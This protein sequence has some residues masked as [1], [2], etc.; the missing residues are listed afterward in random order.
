MAL[1]GAT[2]H[3]KWFFWMFII[4][5][6][7]WLIIGSFKK[8]TSSGRQANIPVMEPQSSGFVQPTPSTV[9]P[10][11]PF[12]NLFNFTFPTS[13]AGPTFNAPVQPAKISEPKEEPDPF[14]GQLSEDEI[15][16]ELA[17]VEKQIE[18]LLKQ[19]EKLEEEEK[20]S[21][22]YGLVFL[23]KGR[24]ELTNPNSEYVLITSSSKLKEPV[25]LID[26]TITSEVTGKTM[27]I[28][29]AS[30]FPRIGGRNSETWITLGPSEKVYVTTGDS[31]LGVSF[32]VNMCSGFLDQ[33]VGYNPALP[34]RC[35]DP[36]NDIERRTIVNPQGYSDEC[37]DYVNKIGRCRAIT[38][39]LPKT[40][41]SSC[42]EFIKDINYNNCIDDNK[43]AENFYSDKQ[44]R[45]FLERDTQLWK[46]RHEIL[47]LLD[48]NGKIIDVVS[49]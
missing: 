48:Q 6:V 16:D 23:S 14:A 36:R 38:A 49:Y 31:P 45:T 10:R 24:A 40:F 44:W 19:L 7:L 3:F 46:S 34:N 33:F 18:D 17:K 22:Y 35:P 20:R 2:D 9:P 11:N 25:S 43:D 15:E 12:S 27:P 30:Y 28:P 5:L 8:D 1:R 41:S 29:Q 37:V 47:K 39:A 42:Q 26:W 13:I 21:P 4:L 32:R